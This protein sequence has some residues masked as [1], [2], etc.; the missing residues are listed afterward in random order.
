TGAERPH[1]GSNVDSLGG[2][3]YEMFAGH[4]PFLGTTA[5]EV[6]ARHSLDAV[7]PLRTIRPELPQAVEHAVRKALAKSPADR[8]RTPAALS[9]ALAQASAPPSVTRRAARAIGLVAVGASLLAAGYALFAR[10][11]VAGPSGEAAHSIR[12]LPFVQL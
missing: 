1:G 4:P 10:R 5:Q 3:L 2:V 7:P 6:L 8:W 11:P 9:D 12:L